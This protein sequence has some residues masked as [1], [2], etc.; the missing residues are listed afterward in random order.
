[1]RLLD[2]APVG[3]S[4]RK[5]ERCLVL[6]IRQ[7]RV[8]RVSNGVPFFIESQ[9]KEA[10]IVLYDAQGAWTRELA[11]DANILAT[12]LKVLNA[13]RYRKIIRAQ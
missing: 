6:G 2:F 9:Q 4:D 10:A 12:Y 7:A 3:V 11:Q 1:M 5:L 13:G 8:P